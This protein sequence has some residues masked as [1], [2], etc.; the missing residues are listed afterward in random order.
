MAFSHR[1]GRSSD[2]LGTQPSGDRDIDE[3][4]VTITVA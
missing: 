3:Q 4:R 2:V 1:K